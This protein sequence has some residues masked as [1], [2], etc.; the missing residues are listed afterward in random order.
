MRRKNRNIGR[1]DPDIEAAIILQGLKYIPVEQINLKQDG[2]RRRINE[3]K[4]DSVF[5]GSLKKPS[6]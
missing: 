2:K 5:K 3:K 6:L 1:E 4:I